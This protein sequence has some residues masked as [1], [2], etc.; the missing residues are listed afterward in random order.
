MDQIEPSLVLD[1]VGDATAILE[2]PFHLREQTGSRK[3]ASLCAV[4]NSLPHRDH[5][6]LI[7][8]PV[9]KADLLP[10]V[11]LERAVLLGLHH[12]N[13]GGRKPASMFITA[14]RFDDVQRLLA[15]A[16]SLHD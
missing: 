6:M 14:P 15:E 2:R 13:P 11:E 16:E 1:E 7:E 9:R 12:V 4:Q 10:I 5:P 3:S 8:P